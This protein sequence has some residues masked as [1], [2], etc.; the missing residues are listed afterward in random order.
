MRDI[1]AQ[2]GVSVVTV[3]RV[4]NQPEKVTPE[5]RARVQAVIRQLN[6]IPDMV[7]G[8][9]ASRRSFAV[10]VIIP[11]IT[12]SLFADTIDGLS[13]TLEPAGY[14]LMIGSSRYDPAREEALVRTMISRRV[15]SLVL[16]GTTHVQETTDLLAQ[17]G[18]PVFEMWNLTP[19]PIDTVIGFSNR[20]AARQMTLYLHQKGYRR[21][22]YL[23]G[24][25]ENND[26]T[27]DRE[28][29]FLEAMSEIGE[30]TAV[31]RIFRA[32]FDF[33]SGSAGILA[34]KARCPDVDAVFAA[35][36]VLAV[37]AVLECHR[38]G[39][40]VP[41]DIAIAGLDDSVIAAQL[42]PSLTTVRLPRY[43]IG[44]E[45][46]EQLIQRLSGCTVESQYI[47]LGFSIVSRESA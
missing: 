15:D 6:Y 26:R 39:W 19:N 34:L 30:P 32:E 29:G 7:A 1:A 4:L 8:S 20:E 31:Q 47:D 3:S 23:G 44:R 46:G 21:I 38:Q 28:A 10:G 2:A 16:T 43:E 5:T 13:S 37:G 25:T 18:I 12:N 22:A 42:T 24:L 11:T 17:S 14:Q 45:I 27:S 9:M 41:H 36:D 35:S 33:P 40:R